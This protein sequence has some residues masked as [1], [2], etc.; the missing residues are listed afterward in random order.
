MRDVIPVSVLVKNTGEVA[1]KEVVLLFTS[2][3]YAS[4]APDVK[5]LRKFTK[6]LLQ[7]GEEQL[8]SFNLTSSDLSF[9]DAQ[10]RRVT[11]TG[12]FEIKIGGLK[13]KVTIT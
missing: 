10:S 7:P 4:L 9:I 6:I 2:D 5:R 1:G 13:G 3:L 8:V 11:E 12:D